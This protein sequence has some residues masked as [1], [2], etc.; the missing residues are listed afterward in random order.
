MC[1]VNSKVAVKGQSLPKAMAPCSAASKPGT[2]YHAQLEGYEWEKKQVTI[3]IFENK[4]LSN[5]VTVM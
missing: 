1:Q 3:S 4:S 2:T 5:S